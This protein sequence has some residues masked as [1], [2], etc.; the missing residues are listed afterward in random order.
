[1]IDM[2]EAQV[3]AGQMA[4]HLLGKRI[5][6]AEL[7]ERKEKSLRD[8]YLLQVKPEDFRAALEGNALSDAYA[9]YR[10]VCLETSGG[11]GLD[12]WD[13]YGKI[14]YIQP[15]A[16]IPGNPPI[17]LGFE[18]GSSLIVLP[19]VWG[20]MRLANNAELRAFR[21]ASDPDLFCEM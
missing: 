21:A 10:H 11:A 12:I 9:K 19:G 4:Q 7:A 1:M 8:D 17:R 6:A 20:A 5:T 15:G 16:K 14:L 3:I 18:D 13:V 2:V